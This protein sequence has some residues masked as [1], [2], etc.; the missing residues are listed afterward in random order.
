M[1]E[2]AAH[3]RFERRPSPVLAEHRPLYKIGQILLVLHLAS[4]GGKSSLPRLHLFNWALKADERQSLL[5]KA[6]ETKKL[7][8]PAWGFDPILAI[9]IRFAMA[10]GLVSENS[11]G[12]EI[13]QPGEIFINDALQDADIFP[14]E[15]AF[16]SQVGKG[17]TEQMVDA[18][19]KGWEAW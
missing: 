17:I 8:V 16:L 14:E 15:R 1:T 7:D 9:A 12:Y 6:A 10:E 13:A 5:V 2:S 3:L 19:A 11:T 18:T 4:R